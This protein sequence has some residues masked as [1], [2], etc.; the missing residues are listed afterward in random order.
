MSIS[1]DFI[2]TA[3]FMVS[4]EVHV[5]ICQRQV[6]WERVS[7]SLIWKKCKSGLTPLRKH[8]WKLNKIFLLRPHFQLLAP[9][10]NLR[11]FNMVWNC[12]IG[13]EVSSLLIGISACSRN[14]ILFISPLHMICF[15]NVWTFAAIYA[16][17][18][19]LKVMSSSSCSQS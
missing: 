15:L 14:D 6:L 19:H 5:F 12:L 13:S 16:I 11:V 3:N 10:I 17:T 8:T 2:G 1:R 7:C 18:P 4:S 9:I